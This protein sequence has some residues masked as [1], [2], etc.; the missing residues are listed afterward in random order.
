M[1]RRWLRILVTLGIAV[2]VC[3]FYAWFFGFQTVMVLETRWIAHR[4]PVVKETPRAL[5]DTSISPVPGT[6]LSYLGYDFEV[7]WDDLDSSKTRS[8]AHHVLL[9]F[10]SGK[11][12]MFSCGEPREFVNLVLQHWEADQFRRLYG[13]TPLQ[14]DYAMHRLI[15]EATPDKVT[16]LTPRKEMIGTSLLLTIKAMALPEAPIYNVQTKDFRGF[17][18]GDPQGR[19]RFVEAELFADDSGVYFLF[20]GQG[21][22]N[23]FAIS[24]PEI[25]RVVQ[26]VHRTAE[27]LSN[28]GSSRKPLA[29]VKYAP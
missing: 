23:P 1:K 12:I 14:S 24:Q 6:K 27:G 19:P 29:K 11:T 13:E 15:E 22:G 28:S 9:A 20:L 3:A 8:S 10:R 16:L 18:Y 21:K 2:V 7:P 5:K 4:A 26:S 17:Q 25:N